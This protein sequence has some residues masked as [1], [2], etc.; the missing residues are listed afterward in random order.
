MN[1]WRSSEN[2]LF[3]ISIVHY[4]LCWMLTCSWWS[5]IITLAYTLG[6]LVQAN[7]YVSLINLGHW[8]KKSSSFLLVSS[9]F[10]CTEHEHVVL[11]KMTINIQ[12]FHNVQIYSECLMQKKMNVIEFLMYQKP[13]FSIMVIHDDNDNAT[14]LF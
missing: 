2:G 12:I 9:I 8:V 13:G 4:F 11:T 7:L 1:K 14:V 6:V 3:P 5:C 10:W